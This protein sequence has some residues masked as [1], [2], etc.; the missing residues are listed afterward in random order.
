RR[1]TGPAEAED[2]RSPPR[3]NR[4]AGQERPARLRMDDRAERPRGGSRAITERRTGPREARGDERPPA[5]ADARL[6]L[7]ALADAGRSADDATA[8][9]HGGRAGG[10][11]RR[12]PRSRSVP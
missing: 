4:D 2:V 9:D 6:E 1:D 8:E 7:D 12:R 5:S 11:G 10:D 3:C